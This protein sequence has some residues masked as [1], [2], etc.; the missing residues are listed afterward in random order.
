MAITAS[1][2][3]GLTLVKFFTNATAVDLNAETTKVALIKD[4]HSQDF[5]THDFYADVSGDEVPGTGNYTTGGQANGTTEVTVAAGVLKYDAVD[6]QWTTSTIAD[7]MA[8][9][10][11]CDAVTD[12]LVCLHDFGTAASTVA[13][14]FDLIWNSAGIF[15]LDYTPA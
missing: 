4:T 15:T 1:G 5:D 2:L 10:I 3:Y 9:V 14:T 11:Y 13:G 6:R 7:A 8:S 12:E